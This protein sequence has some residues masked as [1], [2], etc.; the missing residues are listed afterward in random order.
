[1]NNFS[2]K[3]FE[4]FKNVTEGYMI[5]INDEQLSLFKQYYKTLLEWNE[6]INL[7]SRKGYDSILETHFLDSILFLPEID[8][9]IAR[10]KSP[11][12]S[13]SISREFDRDCF[14]TNVPRN[15]NAP[16]ILDIGSGGGFPGIPLA[17]MKPEWKFTLCESTTKKANF[18]NLLVKE[19]G[20]EKRI[21]V[22]N[23]RV[24]NVRACHGIPQQ[25]DLV[26]ARAIDKLDVLIKYS[27]PLL[28]K[29]AYLLAYKA[30][31]I[32]E[33]IS[34]AKKIIRKTCKGKVTLPLTIFEKE[35]NDVERK[36]VVLG[37]IPS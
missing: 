27:L 2:L 29:G 9:V 19:L 36:L 12:Q 8:E 32:D 28:K 1:M 22:I 26:T 33:E 16:T 13:R 37:I 23:D 6:K 4:D 14:V 7:I 20:F 11:K 24:E 15:D 31:D 35:V 18:L 25:Y 21:T 30:K 17:I 3:N 34:N 10:A 5:E